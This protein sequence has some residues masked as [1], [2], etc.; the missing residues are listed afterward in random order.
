MIYIK[1]EDKMVVY[2]NYRKQVE[3]TIPVDSIPEP[4]D[5]GKTPILMYDGHLYY[6][7]EEQET[8]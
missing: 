2:I 5:N 6:E 7:Y 4:E 3:G 1:V 8:L